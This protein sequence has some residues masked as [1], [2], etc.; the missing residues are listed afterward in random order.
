[1]LL[2]A[3]PPKQKVVRGQHPGRLEKECI[4]PCF[5]I[6]H[7]VAE[8]PERSCKAGLRLDRIMR[9]GV[10]SVVDG[11]TGAG[12]EGLI[13]LHYR[14]ATTIGEDKIVRRGALTEW[15]I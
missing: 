1:M 2:P 10:Q 9:G 5:A 4:H 8:K 3:T 12:P 6:W 7:A 15:I 14:R 13:C 11:H